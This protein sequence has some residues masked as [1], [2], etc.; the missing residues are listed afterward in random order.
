MITS[1]G[2]WNK[3][4]WSQGRPRQLSFFL[5]CSSSFSV[6]VPRP[7][8]NDAKPPCQ[9]RSPTALRGSSPQAG[10]S[11]CP[12]PFP[13]FFHQG[14]D[15]EELLHHQRR[16]SIDDLHLRSKAHEVGQM[17]HGVPLNPLLRPDVGETV[18]PRTPELFLKQREQLGFPLGLDRLLAPWS[19]VRL[20]PSTFERR[21]VQGCGQL[22]AHGHPL[23][24][25]AR[26][27][28]A[29]PSPP[30]GATAAVNIHHVAHTR[31]GHA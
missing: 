15:V 28:L 3:G 31:K 20:G 18:R 19:V 2:C 24:S 17:L 10:P 22:H 7:W 21:V 5:I 8:P 1:L 4:C 13:F 16:R 12:L 6:L 11:S 25:Q 29:L 26:A 9:R 30:R 27:E 14:D 23:V